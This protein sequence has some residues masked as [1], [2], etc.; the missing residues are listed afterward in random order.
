MNQLNK[1]TAALGG[2]VLVAI[3]LALAVPR[4]VSSRGLSA[5]ELKRA[6]TARVA[7]GTLEQRFALLSQRH[8]NQCG[9]TSTNLN[10]LAVHGRLQGSCCRPMVFDRYVQQVNGLQAFAAVAEI[11]ADPYDIPVG[12][13]KRL[14][15]YG[16]SINFS[17]AQQAVYDHAVKLS[18]EH[19]PC[20]CH[21]WRWYAFKG[22][23]T[24]L[25][26]RRQYGAAQV[27]KVWN[28]E[29]GCGG[30]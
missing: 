11:P 18:D 23:A 26:A 30:A 28:L 5:A 24:A 17:G 8:T 12:L 14:T 16:D 29:D 1:R 15:G 27:A 2:A 19:G 9:L 21:C 22:Q 10:Q 7:T 20:C 6:D 13:A 25:I 4:L 3:A